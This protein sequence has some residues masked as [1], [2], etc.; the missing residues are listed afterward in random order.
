RMGLV[1]TKIY[2]EGFSLTSGRVAREN[3]TT[4]REM[5]DLIERIYNK[6]L[7]DE[8]SSEL[9]MDFLKHSKSRARLR[10]GLPIG[11]ELAH[12]TG[13]LRRSCH[14][15]GIV[16]SPQ[17]DYIIAVLTGN[18][19]NYSSAKKFITKIAKHTVDYY[20]VESSIANSVKSG[21]SKSL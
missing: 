9:M 1:Y 19:P 5:A 20:K 11:W 4:A 6:E 7:V 13:L 8:Q 2:P 18:V 12:K 14:D 3:Y 21:R 16:F 17:G 15:V 10:K